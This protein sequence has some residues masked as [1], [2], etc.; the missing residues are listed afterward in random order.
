MS[1][2]RKLHIGLGRPGFRQNLR[3]EVVVRPLQDSFEIVPPHA[4]RLAERGTVL[5]RLSP[6]RCKIGGTEYCGPPGATTIPN[7]MVARLVEYG[8]PNP[9][10]VPGQGAMPP[11]TSRHWNQK[12]LPRRPLP[13][14]REMLH[15]APVLECR[16]FFGNRPWHPGGPA[17]GF[18][19]AL[20]R[21]CRDSAP[22]LVH[23]G[24]DFVRIRRCRAECRNNIGHSCSGLA[25]HR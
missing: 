1:A 10:I 13:R 11:L 15:T 19:T 18:G 24:R 2:L 16:G 25:P 9:T 22:G 4:P 12:T 14:P 8:H 20:W 7:K 6:A 3:K 23:S 5:S 17:A 21:R